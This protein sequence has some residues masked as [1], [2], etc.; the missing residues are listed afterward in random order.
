[1]AKFA[2][3]R[4]AYSSFSLKRSKTASEFKKQFHKKLI[5]QSWTN[6]EQIKLKFEIIVSIL[7]IIVLDFPNSERINL[8][9]LTNFVCF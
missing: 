3:K 2:K 4:L 9:Y 6:L 5:L 1:M 8:F 7:S